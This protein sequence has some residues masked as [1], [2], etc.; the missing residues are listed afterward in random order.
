MQNRYYK[1]ILLAH[2]IFLFIN[3]G[4]NAPSSPSQNPPTQNPIYGGINIFLAENITSSANLNYQYFSIDTVKLSAVPIIK[5][6]SI[7]TYDTTKHIINLSFNNDSLLKVIGNV[8]LYGTAFVVVLDSVRKYSGFFWTPIS[9]I[10]CQI[11]NVVLSW[12]PSDSLGS[13]QIKLSNGYGYKPENDLRNNRDIIN[14]LI[15]DGKA[16]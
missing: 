12:Q 4:C 3:I 1:P 7:I 16:R 2:L 10:P 5:Y 9:S 11:I 13:N 14:R 15:L 8:G 6:E